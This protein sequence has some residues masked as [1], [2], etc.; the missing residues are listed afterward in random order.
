MLAIHIIVRY[1]FFKC[2]KVFVF[3]Q[4]RDYAVIC[5]YKESRRCLLALCFETEVFAKKKKTSLKA[6]NF[7][8][9]LCTVKPQLSICM[10]TG[11]NGW[12]NQESG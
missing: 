11:L 4:G 12:D 7:I 5:S 2:S 8:C 10:G 3:L 1:L 9:N 6:L